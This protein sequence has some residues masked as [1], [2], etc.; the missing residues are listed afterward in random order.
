MLSNQEKSQVNARVNHFIDRANALYGRKMPYPAVTFDVKG[1]CGG[2]ANGS[3]WKVSFNAILLKENWEEY[4]ND[5]IPHE[6]AHLVVYE[7]YG[8]E[9]R[10]TRTGRVQRISHG[11]RW[12]GVMR[13]FG[14]EPKRTHD[15][16]VSNARQGKRTKTKYLY[17]CS[18]CGAEITIGPKYHKDIQRGRG[19]IHKG[20]PSG[21]KLEYIKE[22][23]KVTYTEAAQMKSSPKKEPARPNKSAKKEQAPRKGTQIAHAVLIYKEMVAGGVTARQ[24]IIK[25]IMHSMQVDLKKASGLHDRAK[26]K[27]MQQ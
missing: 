7:L 15:M 8:V 17:R 11:P 26:K 10:R 25:A 12:K 13:D 5:T 21:S 3:Q 6:V 9:Y 14:C 2:T 20:C 27:V 4:M 18:H 24:D 22:L 19:L 1:T 16:D 23:G